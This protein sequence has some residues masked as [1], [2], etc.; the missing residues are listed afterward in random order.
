MTR[1]KDVRQSDY[2]EEFRMHPHLANNPF[3]GRYPQFMFI[4]EVH[5]RGPVD[6]IQS[7]DNAH[8][9]LPGR[10]HKYARG[11]NK[12]QSNLRVTTPRKPLMT[13]GP[14]FPE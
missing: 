9:L 8:R 7:R 6:Q 1:T 2:I 12:P 5:Q 10:T 13:S 11:D 14:T 4:R 3:S